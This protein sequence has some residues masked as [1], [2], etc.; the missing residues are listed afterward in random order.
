MKPARVHFLEAAERDLR[1]LRSYILKNFSRQHWQEA[2]GRI[3][4]AIDT[5][6][7]FPQA[8][9]VPPELESLGANQ[10]HQVIAG[11]NRVIYEIRGNDIF[12]HIII[13]TRKD[14]QSFLT[15]RLL[16]YEWSEW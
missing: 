11:M 16:R 4:E 8:G 13:D 5:I 6:A 1:D 15:R 14:F 3:R 2:Y 9:V 7:R 10:Y 12:I